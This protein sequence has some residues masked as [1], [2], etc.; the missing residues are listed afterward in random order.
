[1]EVLR[2]AVHNLHQVPL[3]DIGNTVMKDKTTGEETS[4]ILVIGLLAAQLSTLALA[5]CHYM[6]ER[7]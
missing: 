2:L 3:N 5:T 4:I 6:E 1:M 7:K